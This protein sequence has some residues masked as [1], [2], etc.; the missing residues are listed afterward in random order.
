MKLALGA[1]ALVLSFCVRAQSL[2]FDVQQAL[3]YGTPDGGK[4]SGDLYV[5][6]PSGRYPAIVA[7]HGGGWQA[8]NATFYRYWGPYLARRGYVGFAIHYR[9][10][11][12]RN[13]CT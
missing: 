10:A 13:T 6:R 2:E 7:V 8:G 11:R 9:L 12:R 1:F 4:I 5:P 3:L